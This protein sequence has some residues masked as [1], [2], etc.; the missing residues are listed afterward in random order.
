MA[1]S[2]I[3]EGVYMG[4]EVTIYPGASICDGV[5]IGDRTT[6]YPNVTLYE[7]VVLG[8]DVTLHSGVSVREGSRIGNRVTIHNG[9]VIGGD[10]F[11]YSPDGDAW[12]KIPQIGIVI[13]ED[14]VEIG[15]N[16]T[17]DRAALETTRIGRGTKIDNHVQVAHNCQ[18]GEN[19]IIVAQ[20][21]IAGST[22]LGN[23]VLIGGQA[24]I[25]DHLTIGDNAQISGQSGVFNSVE[26]GAVMSGTPAIPHK[27]RLKAA[28]VYP[29]LPEMRKTISKLGNRMTKVEEWMERQGG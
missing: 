18:I 9:A 16:V 17:V 5:R 24:A 28:A 20:A 29:L 10:G 1:G 13:I 26:S 15:A 21:G 14:D 6:I 23:H 12:Y 11:G 19:C 25:A 2:F 7:D 22:R 4:Q 3:G 27:S 8:N